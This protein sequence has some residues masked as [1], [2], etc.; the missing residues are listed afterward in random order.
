MNSSLDSVVGLQPFFFSVYSLNID[1]DSWSVGD[2]TEMKKEY[3]MRIRV[4]N[5]QVFG[6]SA[7]EESKIQVPSEE[8]NGH[9]AS[10]AGIAA[11]KKPK[12]SSGG[13]ICRR[14]GGMCLHI[15]HPKR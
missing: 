1:T 4:S 11:L 14:I 3:L 15:C 5:K 8:A 9:K 12:A 6:A 7:H 2:H 13:G 10:A